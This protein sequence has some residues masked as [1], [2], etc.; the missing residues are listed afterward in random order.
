MDLAAFLGW[1]GVLNAAVMALVTALQARYDRRAAWLAA[2]FGGLSAAIAAILFSQS[3]A[4]PER[5][6][7]LTLEFALTLGAGP[8]LYHYLR[9]AT[10]QPTR[11]R[12]TLLHFAPV[13]AFLAASAGLAATGQV[14]DLHIGWAVVSQMTYT[15]AA[16]LVF[17]R[18][19]RADRSAAGFVTPLFLLAVIAAVHA[20]QVARLTGAAS[21][22]DRGL[23]PMI[24]G[25]GLLAMLVLTLAVAQ[26]AHRAVSRR[27]AKS[28]LGE[29]AVR[30]L[31]ARALAALAEDRR[32]RRFDLSLDDLAR[33]VGA[34]PHHLSQ[35]F[36]AADSS[37]AEAV[38]RL[39]CADAA[40]ALADPA[41]ARAA[42]E[43]IGMEA[44]FRSRSA[45]YAAF[46]R[47]AGMTPAEY[48]R[49]A[50]TGETV[51]FPSGQDTVPRAAAG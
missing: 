37:F 42:V 47:T 14:L 23:V 16:I 3:T 2:L 17:L 28:G 45:F 30:S 15:A 13:A 18:R 10:G 7:W 33:A 26:A 40:R 46:G 27:Y 43:A 19:D 5:S 50:L 21:G 9:A 35:A 34:P 4:G 12:A 48:R 8:T 24:S 1:A 11:L 38:A 25:L 39:R 32:Y 49:R 41:N 44:G 6:I 29:A 20:G 31:H 51:S 36:S 22:A